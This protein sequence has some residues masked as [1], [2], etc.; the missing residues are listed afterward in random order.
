MRAITIKQLAGLDSLTIESLPDPVPQRGSV[1]IE[2]KAFGTNQAETYMR[3]AV[4]TKVAAIIRVALQGDLFPENAVV[5]QHPATK[6]HMEENF[7]EDR[8]CPPLRG[9]LRRPRNGDATVD[10]LAS[11]KLL[12][13]FI[14][15]KSARSSERAFRFLGRLSPPM[16][17]RFDGGVVCFRVHLE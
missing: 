1:L 16:L 12:A 10:F 3:N 5:I 8:R 4:G 13:S 15:R 2:V 9:P 6:S 14:I 11:P 7:A 17:G